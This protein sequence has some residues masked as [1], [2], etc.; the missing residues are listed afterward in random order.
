M[1]MWQMLRQARYQLTTRA[2]SGSSTLIFPTG[3]VVVSQLSVEALIGDIP[4]LPMAIIRPLSGQLDPEHGQSAG[5]FRRMVAV[6]LV[7]G[8]A[9]D[10]RGA[11][12]LLGSHR[13]GTTDSRGRGLFEVEE[14]VLDEIA[15]MN[16]RV[17]VGLQFLAATIPEPV[18]TPGD[19]SIVYCDYV[20]E[21]TVTRQRS[22]FA[23]DG[24]TA[25]DAGSGDC[26]L[27]WTLPPDR[28]DR[29]S[30]ILRRAS[31]STPPASYDAGTGVTLSGDLATSVTDSPGAGTH[32][33][34]LFAAYDESLEVGESGRTAGR[35]SAARTQTVVV[36]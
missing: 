22:Y 26:D 31:G 21:A 24:F 8:V 5:I 11:D 35:Y 2:W 13:Q 12:P 3:S 15:A 4:R 23:A 25:T 34:S 36:T 20:H 1:N 6:T 27:A 17:G 18:V 10:H 32:S 28:F 33:Y 7:C 29:L 19:M 30:M 16:A 14:E 9:G